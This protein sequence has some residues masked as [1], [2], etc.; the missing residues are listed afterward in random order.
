MDADIG[1]LVFSQCNNYTKLRKNQRT[2]TVVSQ[3]LTHS[4]LL[5]NL[6]KT[7]E[8][9]MDADGGK[10]GFSHIFYYSNNFYKTE[11]ESMDTNSGKLVFSHSPYSF[12]EFQQADPYN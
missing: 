9:S 7:E 1:K 6:Y 10:L 4:L 8:E 2:L 12:L 11:K 5:Y 3:F